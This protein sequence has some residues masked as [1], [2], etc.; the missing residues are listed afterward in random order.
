L[1]EARRAQ[2]AREQQV[3][4]RQQSELDKLTNQVKKFFEGI[5]W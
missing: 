3:K 4:A 5:E 1:S 2:A